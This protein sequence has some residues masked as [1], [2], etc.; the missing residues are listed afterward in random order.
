MEKLGLLEG[1]VQGIG[2]GVLVRKQKQM[3]HPG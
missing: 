1:R 3:M 2:K